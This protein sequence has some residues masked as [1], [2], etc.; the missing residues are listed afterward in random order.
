[1]EAYPRRRRA[2]SGLNSGAGT[3]AGF[4]RLAKTREFAVG[5][6]LFVA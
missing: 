5:H 1:M 4:V 2:A 6:G 3:A